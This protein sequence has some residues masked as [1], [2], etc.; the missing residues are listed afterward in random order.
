MRS[1]VGETVSAD[2][3]AKA[4][5]GVTVL[6]EVLRVVPADEPDEDALGTGEEPPTAIPASLSQEVRR[7]RRTRILVVEDEASMRDLLREILMAEEYDVV[8][9]AN[10]EEARAEIYRETPDLVLTDL[11][12]PGMDGL[13]L[14]EKIRGDLST[15]DIPVVFLTA[16]ESIDAAVQA[17]DLG[18]D[19]YI[20]KPIQQNL[21][22]SRLRRSLL[23]AHLLRSR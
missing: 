5:R 18:A 2:G 19:D 1:R 17:Y 10:G 3:Q 4:A 15:R 21:L 16:V 22:L 14:L 23:R 9:A 20:S 6:A 13:G 11:H 12:M 8:A 7:S